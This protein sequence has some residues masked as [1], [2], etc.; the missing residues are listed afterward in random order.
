V[1]RCGSV[2]ARSY[3]KSSAMFRRVSTVTMTRDVLTRLDT[4]RLG[5]SPKEIHQNTSY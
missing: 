4:Q 3:E 5:V 2:A 1:T